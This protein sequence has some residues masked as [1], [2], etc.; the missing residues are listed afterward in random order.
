LGESSVDFERRKWGGWNDGGSR[1]PGGSSGAKET[2]TK[3]ENIGNNTFNLRLQSQQKSCKQ[4]ERE[5]TQGGGT[6]RGI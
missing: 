6:R 4:A 3:K 2:G 5:Q 1:E